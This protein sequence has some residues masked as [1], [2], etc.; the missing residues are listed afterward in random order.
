[1]IRVLHTIEEVEALGGYKVVYADCAWLYAQG[2]RGATEGKYEGMSVTEL[3]DL[4][5]GRIASKD[6]V[7]FHWATW[8]FLPEALQ[9]MFAWGFSYKTCGFVW[10]K[11]RSKP[12]VRHVGG[13]F[14][15]RA[16]T[17]FC[18]VG[19][20]GK[21]HPK[22]LATRDARGVR[23][24]IETEWS[25]EPEEILEAPLQEHSAKPREARERIVR[26]LGDLPRVELFARE[27]TAGWDAWGDDPSL[28]GPDVDLTQDGGARYQKR[29]GDET[30]SRSNAT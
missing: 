4:P 24:L 20:R 19:V 2:G 6:S 9:V 23:Q 21:N 30:R 25:G 17:E 26:L 27:R 18:L 28:G 13:G 15:T 7:L 11:H 29:L 3:C 12:E 16:N 22:R 8:P 14:W 5:V 10:V 1:M